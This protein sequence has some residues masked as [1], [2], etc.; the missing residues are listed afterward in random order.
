M[1][2]G[3]APATRTTARPARKPAAAAPP[4]ALS[5]S[6]LV[7]VALAASMTL[8][9]GLL[10]LL[11]GPSAPALAGRSIALLNV[12]ENLSI[13]AVFNTRAPI[14][15]PRWSG[16]VIHHSGRSIGSPAAIADR[17]REQ[18]L[19]GLGYHFVIGNGRRMGDGELHV[20]YR[21]LDQLPGAHVAGPAGMA[22]NQ[23]SIGICLV[24]DGNAE[25][26]TEAQMRRLAEL[27]IALADRFDIPQNRVFL[28]ADLA[29]TTSPGR[30]FP[31]AWL[32]DRLA[33]LPD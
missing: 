14:E 11:A 15:N 24:G 12:T 29:Q 5:R 1:A 18:G 9:A 6:K 33:A 4:R 30:Y 23:Q 10:S 32:R 2:K 27:V 7:W 20:G 28:H 31:Q 26:F 21:W 13:E 22:H 17:Q 3:A 8:G 19:A 16:I 25:P